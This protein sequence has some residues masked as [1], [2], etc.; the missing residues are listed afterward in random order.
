[1]FSLDNTKRKE[2]VIYRI[3]TIQNVECIDGTNLIS[4]IELKIRLDVLYSRQCCILRRF[5]EYN[6][7]SW[8]NKIKNITKLT[9][10]KLIDCVEKEASRVTCSRCIAISRTTLIQT[11]CSLCSIKQTRRWNYW[12]TQTTK[13]V[14]PNYYQIINDNFQLF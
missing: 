3:A 9:D 13:R 7:I 6:T 14:R 4:K 8:R 11:L 5:N 12:T 1:M 10:R 2:R